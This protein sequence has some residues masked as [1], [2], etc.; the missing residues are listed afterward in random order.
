M[1]NNPSQTSVPFTWR[2]LLWR[3]LLT[4][5]LLLALAGPG[6]TLFRNVTDHAEVPVLPPLSQQV[7][8]GR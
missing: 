2:S 6:L 8:E 4:G 3:L 1:V 5:L 7:E